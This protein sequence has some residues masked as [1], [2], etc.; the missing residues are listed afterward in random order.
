MPRPQSAFWLRA[1]RRSRSRPCAGKAKCLWR[2]RSPLWECATRF[3]ALSG[4]PFS[5]WPPS[6]A[7]CPF[8]KRPK[9]GAH[10]SPRTPLH[11]WRRRRC[12]SR[13]CFAPDSATG[14]PPLCFDRGRAG[15]AMSGDRFAVMEGS[16]ADR[17]PSRRTQQGAQALRLDQIR[18]R[19]HR[20]NPPRK[21]SIKA[22][23]HYASPFPGPAI[24]SI[25][26]A[27]VIR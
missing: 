11:A 24:A 1:S 15:G 13:A 7:I 8:R 3:C 6:I 5:P 10:L 12:R 17:D 4:A 19:H 16:D 27:R 23:R 9:C 25:N 20:Q 26:R 14:Q 2:R 18:H 22:T 21:S